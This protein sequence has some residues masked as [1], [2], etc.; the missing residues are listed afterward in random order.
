MQIFSFP[1]PSVM[2]SFCKKMKQ[3]HIEHVRNEVE[4]KRRMTTFTHNRPQQMIEQKDRDPKN[5]KYF[6]FLLF[7]RIYSLFSVEKA[8]RSK[9]I[10]H[11][12]IKKT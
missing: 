3:K 6:W 7:Y 2:F 5:A 11:C 10:K 1:G 9:L 12:S 4:V 8:M